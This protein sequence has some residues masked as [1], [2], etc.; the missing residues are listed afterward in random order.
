MKMKKILV[1]ILIV[2]FE[3][4]VV[5][6][7]GVRVAAGG[8]APSSRLNE[9]A[10]KE[11]HITYIFSVAWSPDGKRL[12]S[13][14]TDKV[15]ILWDTATRKQINA[16]EGHADYITSVAWSPDSKTL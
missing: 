12:A 5:T 14:G 2:A 4:T 6:V 10:I 15:V 11:Q 7:T 1:Y 9:K 16:L 13:G 8:E 3:L